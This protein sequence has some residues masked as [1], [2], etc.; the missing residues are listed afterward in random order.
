MGHESNFLKY[1]M[2]K[3]LFP[4]EKIIADGESYLFTDAH[5]G[6]QYKYAIHGKNFRLIEITA[7][8]VA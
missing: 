7:R 6:R 3:G 8:A 5:S 4:F 1:L 2:N